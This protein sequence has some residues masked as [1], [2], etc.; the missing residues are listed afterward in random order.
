M[1]ARA[2]VGTEYRAGVPLTSADDAAV[3]GR[4]DAFIDWVIGRKGGDDDDANT[5]TVSLQVCMAVTCCHCTSTCLL[6][7]CVLGRGLTGC[8]EAGQT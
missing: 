4:Y 7:M 1:R 6:R 5:Y 8:R 3:S 2:C